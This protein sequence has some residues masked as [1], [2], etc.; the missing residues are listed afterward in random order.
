MSGKSFTFQ[1]RI[2][3]D[4]MLLTTNEDFLAD[5]QKLR[6]KY[7]YP[8]NFNHEYEWLAYSESEEYK[9]FNRDENNLAKKYHIPE[10]H[11]FEF[12]CYVESGNF[13]SNVSQFYRLI[14]L[15]PHSQIISDNDHERDSF[16]LKI[17]PDTTLEDIQNNWPRIKFH[18]DKILGVHAKRKKKIENLERDLEFLRLKREGKKAIEI[19]DVINKDERFSKQKIEYQEVPKLIKRLLDRAEKNKFQERKIPRRLG[20]PRKDS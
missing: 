9:N 12:G 6:S 14:Y 3:Q 8:M 17:Y 11:L 7:G 5:V 18:R 10:S 13:D 16:S 2:K 4:L 15:N 19:R 1:D 20:V